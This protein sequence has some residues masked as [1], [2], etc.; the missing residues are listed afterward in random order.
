MRN[1]PLGA[2]QKLTTYRKIAIASWR[3]PRDPSTYSWMGLPVE[4]AHAFLKAY[5]SVTKP[6]LTHFVGK[7]VAN[8]LEEHPDLNHLLR[9]RNLYR[10]SQTDIFITTLLN[11]DKGKD[12]S[13]FVLRDVP[14]QSLAGVAGQSEE[15]VGR[16][17]RGEDFETERINAITAKMH[18]PPPPHAGR[19]GR[20]GG[21]GRVRHDQLHV[22]SPLRRWRAWRA[23]DAPLPEDL[24]EAHTLRRH[25]RAGGQDDRH[26]DAQASIIWRDRLTAGGRSGRA[27]ASN[28]AARS[29]SSWSM[30]ISPPA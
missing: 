27:E 3:H 30:A 22:R 7:I 4:E 1:I 17:K 18:G 25:L 9:A 15:A 24:P 11:T 14:A 5:P 21:R 13:G 8:C 26:F 10:R 12:L 23:D 28:Q 6:S 16:L 2:K 19:P 29:S 20:A